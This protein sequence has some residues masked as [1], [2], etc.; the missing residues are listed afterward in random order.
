[1]RIFY[2]K[3]CPTIRPNITREY[4]PGIRY[5]PRFAKIPLCTT[6]LELFY[7]CVRE[8]L[9]LEE[10]RRLMGLVEVRRR[11]GLEEVHQWVGLEEVHR[12]IGVKIYP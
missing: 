7:V 6:D 11:M 9:G 2:F 10:V 4:I 3:I 1:M 8:I 5:R 12:R